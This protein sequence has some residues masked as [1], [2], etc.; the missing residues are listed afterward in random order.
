MALNSS[1]NSRPTPNGY[2]SCPFA[3]FCLLMA[4]SLTLWLFTAYPIYSEHRQAVRL[5]QLYCQT[6]GHSE[7]L[8]AAFKK[9]W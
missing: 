1:Q 8:C 4:V 3:P 7:N 2:P 9:G 5:E 6:D